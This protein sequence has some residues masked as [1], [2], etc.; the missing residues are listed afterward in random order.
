MSGWFR[1]AL[2][3]PALLAGL[4]AVAGTAALPSPAQAQQILVMVQGQ[5][6]TSFDVS[7]WIKLVR[8]TERRNINSK[9]ALDELIDQQ[10]KIFTAKRYGVSADKEEVDKM[11]ASMASRNGRTPDQLAAGLA[12]QGLSAASLKTKMQADYVWNSYVRGRFSSVATIRDSDIFAA[13][14]DK[15]EDLTK[16]QRTT[17]YTVRQIVLVVSRTA[18]ASERSRRIG[19]ANALR[20][21][22]TDCES[23]VAAARAM[24]ETVVREPVIRTSA[25]MSEQARKVMSDVPVGHT[26]AP[27]VTQAG[28]ELIAVC[29]RREIVG[30]SVRKKEVRNE[31]QAKQLDSLSKSLLEEARKQAMIQYR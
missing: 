5:P 20:K 9:Q 6:I 26:T 18:P 22:F 13:M 17:E 27:E 11:F 12:Q 30:E 25:D 28:V 31:L 29:G 3:A 14:E 8:L 23:G 4:L 16:A 2:C 15:G 21:N 7:Q 19:E 24:R 1:A 10:L